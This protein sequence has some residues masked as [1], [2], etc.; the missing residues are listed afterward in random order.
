VTEAVT[1]LPA[2]C[3]DLSLTGHKA[4]VTGGSGGIGAAIVGRLRA[5]GATVI[6]VDR[7]GVEPPPG[8]LSLPCN[9]GNPQAID[10]LT[11]AL[12][13][14]HSD[15]DRFVHCAGITRDAV[16]WKAELDDWRRVMQVN[17]DA[18]HQ[19]LR[20]LVPGM[21]EHRR[22]GS[23]VLLSSINGERG[24]LG[25]A[26]YAASKAGLI[27]LAKTAAVEL[28]RFGIRANSI[29][30]GLIQTAMTRALP[31]AI[32]QR[33]LT[34]TPLGRVGQPEDVARAV[35]FLCSEMSSFITGQVLRVDGGQLRG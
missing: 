21:R 22:G 27:G 12:I 16:L 31:D 10:A 6:S 24:K 25:Q 7:P 2:F 34:D 8:A 32:R 26:S 30:P 3:R 33:A 13:A 4:L 14:D 1:A 11:T 15:I 9:L 17:L 19:I 28:G 5:A 23:V 20:A 29:A 35:L 18:A